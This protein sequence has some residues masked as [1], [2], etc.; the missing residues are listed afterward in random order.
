[1]PATRRSDFV[2][3]YL[4]SPD[5]KL[6]DYEIHCKKI[7]FSTLYVFNH[8]NNGCGKIHNPYFRKHLVRL[9]A[10]PHVYLY[11]RISLF[12]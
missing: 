9:S 2:R 1:M 6:L 7:C 10:R 5:H 12:A 3:F 4:I 11:V 8:S